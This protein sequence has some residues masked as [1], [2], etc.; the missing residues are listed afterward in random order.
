MTDPNQQKDTT[1]AQPEVRPARVRIGITQGDTNGVSWEII[2]KVFAEASMLELCT[3]I[4]YG[5]TKVAAYHAKTL[6]LNA[7][8]RIVA[9]ADEAAEGQL[10]LVN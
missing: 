3:P 4:I 8:F 6:G 5:H 10:N 9:D 1:S 2:L 7:Q